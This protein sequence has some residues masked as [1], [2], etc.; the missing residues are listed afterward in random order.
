MMIKQ[1][2]VAGLCLASSIAVADCHIRSSVKLA[3]QNVSF[4]PTDIQKLVSPDPKGSK[5]VLHYR[6]NI[7]EEWRTAEGVGYGKTEDE[8]CQ[9]AMD[10]GRGN[11]LLEVE[12]SRVSADTQMICTDLEDI[13]IRPVRIGETIWE[14]QVDIHSIPA[15][16]KYFQYKF[17]SCRM[18]VE[19]NAKDRN[20]F[21]YQGVICK[22][23]STPYSKWRVVD[24]Y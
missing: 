2:I 10:V 9:Q 17:T 6:V 8:S 12:P 23:N 19:R 13:R 3:R 1:V 20:L 24:K 7:N 5:C 4:G 16:R 22:I 15:E 21:T 18:F 14:S 11:L